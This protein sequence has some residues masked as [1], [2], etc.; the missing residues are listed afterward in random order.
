MEVTTKPLCL[1]EEM[2]PSDSRCLRASRIGVRLTFHRLHSSCS[3]SFMPG[4]KFLL[5]ISMR[6]DVQRSFGDSFSPWS[7]RFV[8]PE[9]APPGAAKRFALPRSDRA[10]SAA[11]CFFFGMRAMSSTSSGR[12]KRYTILPESSLDHIQLNEPVKEYFSKYDGD[13]ITDNYLYT[14]D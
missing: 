5:I 14:F 10:P 9:E 12:T 3:E 1:L 6:I 7:V 13:V 2:K 11:A 8:L 4:G